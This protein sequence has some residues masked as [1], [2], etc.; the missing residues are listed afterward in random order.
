[1]PIFVLTSRDDEKGQVTALGL[2]T[3][4]LGDQA[5]LLDELMASGRRM[6]TQGELFGMGPPHLDR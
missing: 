5:D 4:R 6:R 3:N 2:G 1:V